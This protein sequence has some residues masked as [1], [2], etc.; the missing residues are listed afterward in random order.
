MNS[1]T[2]KK[3]HTRL[4]IAGSLFFTSILA[5]LLIAYLSSMG[6]KYWVLVR[7]L[8]RGVQI[9]STDVSLIKATLGRGAEGYLAARF[10]PMGSITLRNLSSGELL[11]K[12]DL[13]SDSSRMNGASISIAV[14]SSDIPMNVRI[15]DVV[16]LYQVFDSRS[17]EEVP[18]PRHLIGGAFI[19]EISQ[20][21]ANFGGE[22]SLTLSVQQD[23]LPL[24]LAATS[25]GRIVVVADR[26]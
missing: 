7:P 12:S 10:N 3:S 14:K 18:P 5:S 13:T 4:L 9:T 21:G 24:V 15:G 25:S 6:G 22:T 8:P 19:E 20:K 2:E 17:G 11:N 26:G 1:Y 16:T 23:D